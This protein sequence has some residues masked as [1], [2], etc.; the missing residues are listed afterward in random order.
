MHDTMPDDGSADQT[1]S[2]DQQQLDTAEQYAH[3][4][5]HLNEGRFWALRAETL[6]GKNSQRGGAR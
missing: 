5:R 3:E 1:R 6:K 2:D 4:M